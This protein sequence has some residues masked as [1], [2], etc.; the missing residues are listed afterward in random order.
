[1]WRYILNRTQPCMVVTYDLLV[2]FLSSYVIQ[3]VRL[4]LEPGCSAKAGSSTWLKC[5]KRPCAFLYWTSQTAFTVHTASDSLNR[6]IH[7][8]SRRG[9]I[10]KLGRVGLNRS[11]LISLWVPEPSAIFIQLM[12]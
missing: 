4:P 11:S 8:M 12:V 1:M 6:V 7:L 10:S 9:Q 3:Q 2:H 5:F